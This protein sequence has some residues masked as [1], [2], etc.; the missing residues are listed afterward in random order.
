MFSFKI[1]HKQKGNK[2][3]ARTGIISTE[4]ASFETPYLIPVATRAFII[5]LSKKDIKNLKIKA[6]LAN[7]YHLYLKP[8]DKIIKKKGGLHKLMDFKGPI[9]TDSGGFQVFSLGEAKESGATKLNTNNQRMKHLER[10]NKDKSLVKI[11]DKG[12]H[13]KSVY[14]NSDHYLDPKKSMEIQS[15]L[16]SDAIMAFDECPPSNKPYS[17]QL[18]S[19]NRTN[20]WALESLQHHDKKQALYGIIQGGGYKSLREK[21]AKFILSNKFDGIAIGGSFGDSYGDSKKAMLKIMDWLSPLIKSDVRPRHMLG[22][23]W[24]DDIFQLVDR[25]IDT[26]DCVHMTRI[27]RHGNLFISPESGGNIKNKFRIK[28]KASQ[29][30]DNKEKIDKT[31]RCEFCKSYN[32]KEAHELAKTEKFKFGRLATIHNISF[33]LSLMEK[34]RKSIKQNT[35]P[36]LKKKWIN[37]N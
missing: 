23:G 29:F 28:I 32:R 21:S 17:Y 14:D 36:K 7:T 31:C 3:L 5:G 15:N 22:I 10:E 34:I 12:V 9:Y 1:T 2:T 11:T 4:T 13:F 35:F 19:L 24:I 16:G 26:F 27:A 30:K 33:M 25:G 18:K 8:G 6:L 20:I 37:Q